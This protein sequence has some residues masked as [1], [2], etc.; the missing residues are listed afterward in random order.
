MIKPNMEADN[1]SLEPDK[2]NVRAPDGEF[3]VAILGCLKWEGKRMGLDSHPTS[4]QLALTPSAIF[5]YT[6][7]TFVLT[8]REPVPPVT[9]IFKDLR[10]RS[11]TIGPWMT[12]P[13]ASLFGHTMF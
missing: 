7:S 12:F 11:P 8:H 5:A 13:T 10:Q 9:R 2:K 1:Q 6:M 4:A 3:D